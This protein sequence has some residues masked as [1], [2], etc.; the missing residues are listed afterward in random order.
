VFSVSAVVTGV[1]AQMQYASL[2]RAMGRVS[3]LWLLLSRMPNLRALFV[4]WRFGIVPLALVSLSVFL[5]AAV[6]G[7]RQNAQ[8]RLLLAVSVSA[9]IPYYLFFHDL[10]VLAL[11]LL[12]GINESIARRDWL[13]AALVSAVLS[14]FSVFWFTRGK[15]YLAVLF[16]LLFFV[17]QAIGLWRESKTR[18][19]DGAESL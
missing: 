3:S 7:A 6:I 2:L 4:A 13:R 16:T 5:A 1:A 17:T 11:P 14:G 19:V 12:L 18:I 8:Q 10:S 15:L 9:L